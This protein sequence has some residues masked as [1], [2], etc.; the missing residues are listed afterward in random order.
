MLLVANCRLLSFGV[1]DDKLLVLSSRL[2]NGHKQ[3]SGGI[4]VLFVLD[5]YHPN[6]A[7]A[8]Q[9]IERLGGECLFLVASRHLRDEHLPVLH[10]VGGETLSRSGAQDLLQRFQPSIVVQRSFS[11]GK[12]RLWKEARRANI[13][14]F[15]YDQFPVFFPVYHSPARPV[16]VA[17]FVLNRLWLFLR[18]GPYHRVSPVDTWGGKRGPIVPGSCHVPA[19]IVVQPPPARPERKERTPTVLSIA[20][21]GQRR[22]RVSWLLRAFKE[23]KKPFNLVI[24][25]W[26]PQ[27]RDRARRQRNLEKLS[28]SFSRSDATVSH[29]FDLQ[30]REIDLLMET[31]DLF[32]L[33]SRDEPFAISP[34]EA[35][36][37]GLPVLVS[38][39][40][41][42]CSYVQSER[43]R[44]TFRF[45]SYQ[46]FRS[47]LSFLISN[48]RARASIGEQNRRYLK[49]NHDPGV[50]GKTLVRSMQP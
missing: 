41:G 33:P 23:S 10:S 19:P 18:I 14:A 35:M 5:R 48:P 40:G 7:Q 39:D 26:K 4:S 3:P 24:V 29:L 6:L 44:Q 28:R 43:G 20:K 21:L 31:A 36:A 30:P 8:E 38:S 42:A 34:L 16:R 13:P 2:G 49:Q 15:V 45:N 25:S 11:R 22:K 37:F 50:F 47:R 27:R 1:R 46:D 32:V 12:A 9:C 17:K